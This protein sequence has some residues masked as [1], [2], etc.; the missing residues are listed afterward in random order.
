[1]SLLAILAAIGIVG[2]ALVIIYITRFGAK[3]LT[4]A[5]SDCW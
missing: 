3:S 4:Q 1:M 5:L 2:F